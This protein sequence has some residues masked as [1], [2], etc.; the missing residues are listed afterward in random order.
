[1]SWAIWITGLPGS[2]KSTI[3]RAAAARLAE[4]GAPIAL[5]ELDRIRA[6]V[7]PHPTYSESEREIVYRSLVFA[8]SSAT[9]STVSS[10]ATARS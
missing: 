2:G 6:V 1:M 5:L 10:G 8:A 3:A 9:V 7:T 4:A